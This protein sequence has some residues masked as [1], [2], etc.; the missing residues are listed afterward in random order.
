MATH[1]DQ[2]ITKAT[3]ALVGAEDIPDLQRGLLTI[4]AKYGGWSLPALDLIKECAFVGGAAATPGIQE[5]G[6]PE[7]YTQAFMHKRTS[8]IEKAI[9]KLSEIHGINIGEETNL[10]APELARGG[11][12]EKKI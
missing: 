12:G 4:P 11:F 1:L 9:T 10:S 8:E 2:C 7:K 6:I 5:W 3:C